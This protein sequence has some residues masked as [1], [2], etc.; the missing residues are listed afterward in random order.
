MEEFEI[1]YSKEVIRKD[2]PK[3]SSADKIRIQK[4][5]ENKLT[6][7]PL[8]FGVSL[9]GQLYGLHKLR[10]GDFRVIFFI[11]KKEVVITIIG[12]RS[13]VYKD[14]SKRV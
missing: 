14:V 3:L 4:A 1:K 5:I 7:A 11:K 13:W 10:V 12:H 6:S 8:T 9:R 2:I